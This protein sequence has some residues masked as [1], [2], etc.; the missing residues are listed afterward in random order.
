MNSRFDAVMK[1]AVK[2]IR[3]EPKPQR[4]AARK[5]GP[6]LPAKKPLVF[7]VHAPCP[8]CG[9]FYSDPALQ[10]KHYQR[11]H[12]EGRSN[13]WHEAIYYPDAEDW[14]TEAEG[15]VRALN[16]QLIGDWFKPD[17]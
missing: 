4:K 8:I 17:K 15:L 13:P 14:P 9:T 2:L 3:R 1:F 12:K 10:L 11:A 7:D 6:A 5:P 16:R